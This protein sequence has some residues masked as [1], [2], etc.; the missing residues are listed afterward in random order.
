M[1]RRK[2]AVPFDRK[3]YDRDRYVAKLEE[4]RK[5]QAENYHRK[6]NEGD[7]VA[8]KKAYDEKRYLAK[9]R[10]KKHINKAL[11]NKFIFF[12]KNPLLYTSGFRMRFATIGTKQFKKFFRET[13]PEEYL[14]EFAND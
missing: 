8:A 12:K 7:R 2:R 5:Q 11:K 3:K 4:K 6:K 9:K 14:K 1:G 10:I 13:P